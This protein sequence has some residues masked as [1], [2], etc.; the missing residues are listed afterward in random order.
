M[1]LSRYG[2]RD[3]AI[4]IKGCCFWLPCIVSDKGA[5]VP[6]DGSKEAPVG[7]ALR[8]LTQTVLSV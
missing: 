1:T 2:P 4:I 3:Y 5:Y 7:P 8:R 6:R